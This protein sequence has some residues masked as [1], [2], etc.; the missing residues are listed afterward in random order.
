MSSAL[1]AAALT[2]DAKI[3]KKILGLETTL[4]VIS[5]EEIPHVMKLVKSLKDS[6]LLIKSGGEITSNES[7]E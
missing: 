3:Y 1:K 7:W 5:S 4:I 6:G 2:V